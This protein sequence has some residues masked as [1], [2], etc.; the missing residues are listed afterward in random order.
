MGFFDGFAFV[1]PGASKTYRM[2]SR[3][4]QGSNTGGIVHVHGLD[5]LSIPSSGVYQEFAIRNY[6]PRRSIARSNALRKRQM[7]WAL[8][9]AKR[10]QRFRFAAGVQRA[11]H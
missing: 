2:C 11:T 1:S 10:R 3:L 9:V 5:N 8:G 4:D 7:N 6:L